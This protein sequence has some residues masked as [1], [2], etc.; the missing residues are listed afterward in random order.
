MKAA[1]YV[2][3]DGGWVGDC[4]VYGVL[5]SILYLLCNLIVQAASGDRGD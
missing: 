4:E 5:L 2:R 1:K 3:G